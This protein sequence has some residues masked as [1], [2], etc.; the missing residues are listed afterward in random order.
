LH[1]Q[2][3][4]I[5]RRTPSLGAAGSPA[6]LSSHTCA[7]APG[8]QAGDIAEHELGHRPAS[9]HRARIAVTPCRQRHQLDHP[10]RQLVERLRHLLE[11]READIAEG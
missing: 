1:P 10:S 2:Q 5:G 11:Q 4:D 3:R 8:V 6:S 9:K 7:R